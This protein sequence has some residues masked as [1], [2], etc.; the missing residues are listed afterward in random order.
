MEDLF[1]DING[2]LLGSG[3]IDRPFISEK[4]FALEKELL[5][6]VFN[7]FWTQYLIKQAQNKGIMTIGDI[8]P[9]IKKVKLDFELTKQQDNCIEGLFDIF[10]SVTVSTGFFTEAKRYILNKLNGYK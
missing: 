8:E 10:V 5:T 7:K 9:I 6:K 4:E 1:E 3:A 2:I